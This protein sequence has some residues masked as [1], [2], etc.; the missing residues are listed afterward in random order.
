VRILLSGSIAETY[1]ESLRCLAGAIPSVEERSGRRVEVVVT[2][3]EPAERF[4]GLGFRPENLVVRGWAPPAEI[5]R[6]G[7]GSHC[8][9]VPYVFDDRYR[10]FFELSFPQR[11]RELLVAGAPIVLHAPPTSAVVGY[12]RSHGLPFVCDAPDR[13]A[14]ARTICAAV[15]LTGPARADLGARYRS[16]AERFHRASA[17]RARLLEE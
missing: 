15:E 14:L 12:F 5:I 6:W 1:H 16:V 17:I 9:F 10:D 4:H 2:G 3:R 7:T 13:E 11:T 8:G